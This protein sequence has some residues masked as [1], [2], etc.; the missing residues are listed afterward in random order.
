M[1]AGL[2]GP[3]EHALVSLL[4]LNGLRV[5]EAVSADIE[6]LTVQSLVFRSKKVGFCIGPTDPVDLL[7]P[8]ATW[9]VPLFGLGSSCGSQSALWV[10]EELPVGWGDTYCRST[11]R[12]ARSF[13]SARPRSGRRP[14]TATRWCTTRPSARRPA[15]RGQPA[16][17]TA[18]LE[19]GQ[20]DRGEEDCV[21]ELW[22][23]PPFTPPSKTQMRTEP[24]AR[25]TSVSPSAMS[26]RAASR[27]W[28]S[29]QVNSLITS[30]RITWAAFLL[31][32]YVR[33]PGLP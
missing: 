33:W 1:T 18:V 31:V 8:H 22:M 27:R 32:R 28:R 21:T 25:T 3:A 29:S 7:L 5:S 26:R 20:L 17:A 16:P 30:S 14:C 15:G 6:D 12:P 23:S 2:G 4:A 13:R 11:A 19:L 10:Q 24:M 9:V